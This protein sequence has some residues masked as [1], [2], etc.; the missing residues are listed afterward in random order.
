MAEYSTGNDGVITSSTY[1]G[2]LKKPDNSADAL[3]EIQTENFY[4]TLSSY[5][6][7]REA[8]DTFKTMSHVDFL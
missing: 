7:Y 8:D 2:D 4:N 3:A 6:S 1:V 5:Y